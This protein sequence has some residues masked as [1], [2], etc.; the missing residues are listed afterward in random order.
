MY[1]F[2]GPCSFVLYVSSNSSLF[3]SVK[4]FFVQS[5]VRFF[6]PGHNLLLCIIK[7][8]KSSSAETLFK[9]WENTSNQMTPDES[10]TNFS[11]CSLCQS[12]R[13]EV[14]SNRPYLFKKKKT[15]S[16]TL[17]FYS[18]KPVLSLEA[19]EGAGTSDLHLSFYHQLI[20]A[21][22]LLKTKPPVYGST[23]HIVRLPP[24]K[25]SQ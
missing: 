19:S 20:R 9:F 13:R 6:T 22:G 17:F 25:S 11:C 18:V 1:V 5:W 21:A 7:G 16:P 2:V 24:P 10:L 23:L 3:P 14:K 4:S 15:L 8:L 12:I